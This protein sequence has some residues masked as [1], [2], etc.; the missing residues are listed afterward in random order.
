MRFAWKDAAARWLGWMMSE[1]DV[2]VITSGKDYL[3]NGKMLVISYD[4]LSR[5]EGNNYNYLLSTL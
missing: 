2:T 3:C 5:K 4:L 1:D